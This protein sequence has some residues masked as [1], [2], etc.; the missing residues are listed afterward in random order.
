MTVPSRGRRGIGR[1]AA[2]APHRALAL[3]R[4]AHREV[5]IIWRHARRPARVGVDGPGLFPG[6]SPAC[7]P[8]QDHGQPDHRSAHTATLVSKRSSVTPKQRLGLGP[9]A[10]GLVVAFIES[11]QAVPAVVVLVLAPV[12]RRRPTMAR[13]ASRSARSRN[14]S[15]AR[16]AP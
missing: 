14:T 6:P 15:A 2:G 13:R 8:R 5:K 3:L 11:A 9:Q 4:L 12:A 7:R 16:A 10:P 1:I